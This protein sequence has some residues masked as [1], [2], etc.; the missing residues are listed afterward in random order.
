MSGDTERVGRT[1]SENGDEPTDA[2][3]ESMSTNGQRIDADAE[4]PLEAVTV[5]H[6]PARTSAILATGA[7]V[8]AVITSATSVLAMGVG[9]FGLLGL[10][11][12]LFVLGSK[13]ATAVGTGVVFLGVVLSGVLG[14]PSP[15][16]VLGA[17]AAILAF[18][19]GENAFSVGNQLSTETETT[20]GELVHA[21]ASVIAG[22]LIVG[23][24]AIVYAAGME[25]LTYGALSFL[26]FGGLLLVWGIR[27]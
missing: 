26:L 14:N 22:T 21:A 24:G 27:T 10:I 2:D 16:L 12:G 11:T 7:G 17:M 20:R 19:F 15:L 5:T 4:E 23:V 9:A 3:E 18:D 6:S 13:R 1:A 25:G 8:L